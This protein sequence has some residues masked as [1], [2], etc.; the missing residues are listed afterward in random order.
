MVEVF[1][2]VSEGG[3]YGDDK[4]WVNFWRENGNGQPNEVRK[5][6]GIGINFLYFYAQGVQ[7]MEDVS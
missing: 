7:I 4:G 2:Y 3:H 6:I 5:W 1:V